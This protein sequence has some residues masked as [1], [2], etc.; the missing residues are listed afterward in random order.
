MAVLHVHPEKISLVI[1]NQTV[2]MQN[3]ALEG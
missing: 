2:M 1:G 3:T